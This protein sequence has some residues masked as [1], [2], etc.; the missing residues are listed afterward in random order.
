MRL[1]LLLTY[2]LIILGVASSDNQPGEVRA[3]AP[4]SEEEAVDYLRDIK[5]LLAEKCYSCHG[6]LKQEG[7]LR[8]DTRDL[9]LEASVL[10]L[11]DPNASVLLERVTASDDSRMPPPDEGTA[12]D[13]TGVQL[14]QQWMAQGAQAPKEIP[15][16]SPMEHWAFQPI[17]VP[18][19]AAATSVN[20]V[21]A[22]LEAKHEPLHLQPT[23]LAPRSLRLR[24][25]YLD[26][27]GLP[28]TLA[29]LQ[30]DRPWNVIVEELLNNPQHG[31]RWARHWMDVWRYS[32]D[33][34]LGAQLRNS[35]K[36]L[37]HWR[38]WIITSLNE[39]KGYDRMVL[40]M[41]AGDELEPDNPEVVSGT[42]FL[43]RNYYLFNR[44]TWLD[45]T[46]EHT[47]KAFLG[48][49][50]NCAKCHD[51]K[52]DP[53]THVDYYR[54]RAIFEPHQVRLDPVP[55]ETDLAKNG[56][57]RVFDDHLTE[58]TFL[59]LRGN[60]A[61][62]DPDTEITPGVPAI[63]A[64]FERD[65][66]PV[67]LPRVAFEPGT[68]EYVVRDRIAVAEAAVQAAAKACDTAKAQWTATQAGT[69][70]V[71]SPSIQFSDSFDALN[72]QA[73][74]LSG[75]S[76]EY[77][78]GQ[79]LQSQ[80]DR[81]THFAVLQPPL[82]EN[83]ELTC[84]YTTTG[85][86]TYKSVIFRFDENEDRSTYNA[87]YTSAHEP[88][89]KLQ[90]TFCRNG[91]QTYPA[92]GQ[93]ARPIEVGQEY[94]LRFAVHG[95]LVNV[96]ID[97]EFQLA[98]E[99][100]GR[101]PGGKLSLSGFDATVAF[102]E[103]E[104]KELGR[105][106]V[107]IPAGAQTPLSLE[108]A[109][110]EWDIAEARLE[111]NQAAGATLQAHLE[112]LLARQ[113]NQGV[114]EAL[115]LTIVRQA[116]EDLAKA[117]LALLEAD[118]NDS[119][120][121]KSTH[122]RLAKAQATLAEAKLGNGTFTPL[123]SSL[124]ALET[125]EHTEADYSAVY[126]S[127]S[128]GRRLALARWIVAPEN[129]LTARVAVNHIW[130]RHFGEPLV[131]SVFDFGLRA[132]QPMQADVLDYLAHELVSSGWSMKHVHRILVTSQ[133]YQ[134]SSSSV[135][136]DANTVATDLN[137][138]YYWR[139]NTRRMESQ[140]V[141][142][143]MLALS[144]R[145]DRTMGGPSLATD[146]KSLRRSLYYLHS[147]DEQDAFLGTFDDAD[148]LGCY[149]RNE[150]VVPQQ[151]LA[152]ANSGLAFES[153]NQIAERLY[154]DSQISKRE[155]VE[156][157]FEQLLAR[158]ANPEEVAAC[159]QFMDQISEWQLASEPPIAAQEISARAQARLVHVL[160]NHNDFISIR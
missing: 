102:N 92:Q 123:R 145:L 37:W 104:V 103:L 58:P 159:Q 155:F 73:W 77:H 54:F 49:T 40:E 113:A 115:N 83:F 52:Y 133:A 27:I 19:M 12:V 72:P 57:P 151:A 3:E 156:L 33:Y 112:L 6:V 42:G 90:I 100:P 69:S 71:A 64:S 114:E 34:G 47:S 45:E 144:G 150:S 135:S 17:A 149:R 84:R 137:N 29:Q 124:K 4:H 55:G 97:D 132:P 41:L 61:D 5:T 62:P 65:I 140:V 46:I 130:M 147:R 44:T 74:E 154:H 105:D 153:A 21:D 107:L 2:F 148:L 31:E 26:L 10:D 120:L 109:Q 118:P 81:D 13:A 56:L 1:Q 126:P 78:D 117:E 76:W 93:L 23:E 60:P 66:E 79:L 146:G 18:T 51:H 129:P 15:P 11:D 125:P 80:A 122:E 98:F 14:L 24:R 8:L 152:L 119:K 95:S 139:M 36:H 7:G 67:N 134:R 88:S 22:L 116:S 30:D 111:A 96:W 59:H 128:T 143:S 158:P 39:D 48:L 86:S 70:P 141:R 82:P 160:L 89:P 68:R 136:A 106:T 32:D 50:L 99:L 38:D 108:A 94:H 101:L 138:A 35:Q 127:T 110:R 20:P 75:P 63:L 131:E 91:K 43:A 53:L 157:A 85:G 142:D 16:E 9:M 87:V 121:A 25:L 28:P